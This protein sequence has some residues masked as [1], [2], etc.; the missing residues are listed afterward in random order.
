MV[1][2]RREDK[3]MTTWK[4]AQAQAQ[5]EDVID[6]ARREGPQ[7]IADDG[8]AGVVVLS[9]EDYRALVNRKPDFR[10]YLLGGPKIDDFDIPRDKDTGR[11][12]AL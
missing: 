11:D 1:S 2:Q 8:D 9:L 4:V 3:P 10:E 5:L 7:T 6:R 12:I